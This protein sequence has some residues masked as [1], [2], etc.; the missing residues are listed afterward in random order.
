MKK[1][2]SASGVARGSVCITSRGSA[3]PARVKEVRVMSEALDIV[4]ITLV[5]MCVFAGLY[6]VF[7]TA[8]RLFGFFDE[9]GEDNDSKM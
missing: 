2:D 6:A 5:L 8:F 3:T 1:R 7:Y 9:G 4:V